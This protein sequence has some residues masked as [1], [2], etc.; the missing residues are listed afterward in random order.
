MKRLMI[1]LLTI[2]G[3][4]SML[5]CNDNVTI[6]P[7]SGDIIFQNLP[8]AQSKAIQLATHSQYSHVGIIF[9]QNGKPVVY[10]AVQPVR[11]TPLDEWIERGKDGRFIIKR[12][13]APERLADSTIANMLQ[14]GR[15]QI[16]KDYD[17]YFGWSDDL[18]YCSEFVWK[19]YQR[20]A[21]IE[22]C[23]LRHLKDFDLTSTTVKET[24]KRRYGD[25]IPYDERVVAPSD[26]FDSDK[27][28][29]VMTD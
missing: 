13:R 25:T 27:L 11:V 3:T 6:L 2:I 22:L 1:F 10:E 16:G 8:S 18:W 20:G 21:G 5:G 4:L 24:M 12:L 23:D 9:I 26:I 29:T 14:V 7:R 17:I 15:H 28:K 19:I